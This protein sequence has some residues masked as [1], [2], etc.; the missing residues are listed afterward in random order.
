MLDTLL[1]AVAGGA[2]DHGAGDRR[3]PQ[4][5]DRSDAL[6]PAFNAEAVLLPTEGLD[7]RPDGRWSIPTRSTQPARRCARRL[8]RELEPRSGAAPMR[9]A[10]ANRFE[11]SP[12]AKGARRLRT[13]ALGYLMAA[14]ARRRARRWRRRQF[15]DADNMTDRQGALG[16]LANSSTRPSASRRSPPSTSAIADDALVLDKWFTLQALSTPRRHARRGRGAAPAIPI[17]R[18]PIPT[19]CARW[20]A[21]FARQPARVPRRVRAR[22][23]L[24]RRHDPRASTSSIRRSRRG[25]SR[26]S[27]AGAAST[28]TA[29]R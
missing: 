6:D 9:P 15:D 26:R 21:A 29:P 22:L 14:G 8:G 11:L 7:R 28:R 16:V 19:G 27:A 3:G 24:P 12:A 25:W 23:S 2:A 18:S 20:S 13:V 17:S 5:A 1:A 10:R 4:H